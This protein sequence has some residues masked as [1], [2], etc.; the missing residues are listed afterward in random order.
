MKLQ[1]RLSRKYKGKEY[2]KY[3][4]VIPEREI[5]KANLKEGD[6]LST[7]SKKGEIILR[8]NSK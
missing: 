6:E 8:N 1:K 7:D 3:I 4:I 5:I 2:Y